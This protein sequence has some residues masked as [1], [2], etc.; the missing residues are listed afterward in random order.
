MKVGLTVHENVGYSVSARCWIKS[1]NMRIRG[2]AIVVTGASRG[3]GQSTARALARAGG[4][5]ALLARSAEVVQVAAEIVAEG[6]EARAYCVDLTD[7][8]AVELV[9][10]QI[11]SDFGAPEIVINNAGAGRWLYVEETP[12][13][14][15]AS[16][17]ACPY[18]SA[19]YVTRVFLPSLLARREG[20]IVNINSP[21][22][23]L[24]WPGASAYLAARWAIRGF[25]T[26]LRTD[27]HGTGVRVLALVPGRTGSTYFEHNP[28][29]EERLPSITR[30][31]PKLTPDEVAV[32]LVKGI[33]RDRSEI[34][35]PLMLKLVFIL[36]AVAPGLVDWMMRSTGWHREPK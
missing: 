8:A 34:V 23:W 27:L 19:F 10:Q 21:V 6:G 18:L 32:A 22:A 20:Y 14:E 5:V 11:V 4:R 7:P 3:I 36:H 12:P 15:A 31:I 29:S 24:P 9:G 35:I 2:R 28:N 33:E 1:G 25:T 26:A 17:I 13:E 30:L 16:M